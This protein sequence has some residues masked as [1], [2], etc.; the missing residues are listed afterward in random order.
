MRIQFHLALAITWFIFIFL[1]L[2]SSA[3]DADSSKLSISY[4]EGTVRVQMPESEGWLAASDSITLDFGEK[5]QASKSSIA[6]LK[7]DLR[8][9]L[10]L[11]QNSIIG[12]INDLDSSTG[13]NNICNLLQG[14]FWINSKIKTGYIGLICAL[15]S[16]QLSFV[17]IPDSFPAI[18]RYCV[19][20]DSTVEARAYRGSLA[21]VFER[22][23]TDGDSVNTK[24]F[25]YQA[26]KSNLAPPFPNTIMLDSGE[27]ILIAS[28][29]KIVYLGA[30]STEDIDENTDWVKWNKDRD[31]KQ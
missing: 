27:K 5:L 31:L 8:L 15:K 22:N 26:E 4:L 2:T 10:R 21:I 29:G 9:A 19:A 12:A 30:F 14:D 25:V 11:D 18:A 13:I 1:G 17:A 28:S 23:P 24:Y 20:T 7:I 3:Q 6:E 16:G